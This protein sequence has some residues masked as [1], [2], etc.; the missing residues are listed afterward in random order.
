MS[1]SYDVRIWNIETLTGK[2]GTTYRVRRVVGKQDPFQRTFSTKRLAES[3][4]SDLISAARKGEAF[5]I[6]SGLPQSMMPRAASPDWLTFAMS[7]IDIKWPDFSP[8]TA[9]A[10]LTAWSPSRWRW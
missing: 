6:A 8:T 4:R 3:F 9:R 5:D 7:Y 1:T 2:R 10:Q